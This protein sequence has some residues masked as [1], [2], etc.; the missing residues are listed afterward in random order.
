MKYFTPEM[1]V[2]GNE[3]DID[4]DE[5][6]DE[7]ERRLETYGEQYQKIE[8]QLPQALQRFNREQ[9]LHDADIFAPAVMGSISR[10]LVLVAQQVNT[11]LPD[12]INTLAI[13]IFTLDGEP[14]VTVPV[15][16]SHF[17]PTQP[18]WLYEEVSMPAPGKFV[19][20][21]LVSD[22]RVIRI[23]FSD[24][25]YHIAPLVLP[26]KTK[27]ESRNGKVKPAQGKKKA[28]AKRR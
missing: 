11:L 14:S 18:I 8:A 19:I 26:A 23:P 16:S 25:R 28:V 20:E 4:L 6:D 2:Q 17:H 1:Y 21:I 24:F 12:T 10:E 3:E 13:L 5:H 15:E 7:W 22:G 9:C 27:V